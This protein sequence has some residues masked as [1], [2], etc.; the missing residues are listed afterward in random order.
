MKTRSEATLAFAG[1]RLDTRKRLLI[2]PDGA[3]VNLSS[4]AFDTLHYL[5]RH[6][7]D[8][9][10]KQQLMKAVWPH[11]VVEENNLNQQIS[12]LRK[13]FGG[14]PGDFIVTVSG[15]GYKFVQDVQEVE[16]AERVPPAA[17]TAPA[18]PPRAEASAAGS[19]P[20]APVSSPA[21]SAQFRWRSSWSPAALGA[22]VLL[23]GAC[24]FL[25]ATHADQAIAGLGRLQVVR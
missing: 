4:R 7:H 20:L 19:T 22:L 8:L 5:V 3:P 2:G 17:A 11:S 18:E 9:I 23:V 14:T 6:P 16:V 25:A 1:Y 21:A 13:M 10:D 15:R 12:A 24:A